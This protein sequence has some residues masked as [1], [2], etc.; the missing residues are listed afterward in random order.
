M[1]KPEVWNNVFTPPWRAIRLLLFALVIMVIA[2]GV[3]ELKRTKGQTSSPC[4]PSYRETTFWNVGFQ[5]EVT[6]VNNGPAINGW[7]VTFMFPT[8]TQTIY[9]LW[10]GTFTQSGQTVTVRNASYNANIPTGG[11]IVFG[12]NANWSGSHPAPTGFTLNGQSCGGGGGA[13]VIQTSVTTLNVNEG[14]SAQLGVRLSSAPASNVTVN[15]AR[16]SGDTDLTVSGGATLTF[17]PTNFGTFQNATISA[18][19]DADSTNGSAIIRAS[20]TGLP[21]VDVTANEVDNDPPPMVGIQTSVSTL[22]VNEGGSAQFGVRLSA[23]PSGGTATVNVMRVSGDTD[24]TV[25]GGATLTF[26]SANFGTFQNVTINA[27]EDAD[28]ANGSAVFRASGTNLGSADVTANEVDNDPPAMIAIQTSVATLNVNEGGSAQYGVRLASAPAATVTV[29]VARLSGDTDLT[30]TGGATLMF[31][32]TNFGTFQNVTISAAQD[33]DMANGSAVIRASGANLISADVTANEVD[34]DVPI[35]IQTNLIRTL[36]VIEN[37][38]ATFGVR[39]AAAPPANVTVNVA[40]LNGDADLR[41]VG[42]GTLTFTP[43]NFSTFQNVT[44][45]A[46]EDADITNGTA[47]FQ[48]SGTG[49]TNAAADVSEFDNDG[50]P[51]AQRTFVAILNGANEVPPV[52]TSASG[53]STVILS[54]DE[55]SALVSLNFTGLGSPQTAAHLHGPAAPGNNAPGTILDLDQPLGQVSNLLWNIQP[56][57]GLSVLQQVVALKSG[58]IY[59][60]VHTANNPSG[61]IRGWLFVI[62]DGIEDPPDPGGGGFADA[63]RFLEQATFGPTVAEVNRVMQIGFDPWLNEQ[64]ALPITGYNNLVTLQQGTFVSYPRKLQFFR[65][66]MTA[67]DQ[68]RQRVAW[69]LS[70]IVVAANIGDQDGNGNPTAMVSQYQ[71]ILLRNAFG[72]YRTLIREMSVS[73]IMGTYLTLVNSQRANT[74]TGA[75]PD[76]NYIRELWQLFTIGTFR[77]NPN[78]TVMLDGQGRPLEAYT[79]AEIQEGARALTGWNYAPAAGQPNQGN[80]NPLNP[81]AAMITNAANHDTGSKTLLTYP[82]QQSTAVPAN[83]T[84]EQ[85]LD[86]VIN[87]VFNHPNVGPFI[88]RQLIQHLVTSNPSPAYVGRITAVFNNNGQ[89]VRGDLR[90]VVRAI[91]LDPE[92]RGNSKVDPAYG[93]LREPALFF[94]H[95]FRGLGCTGGMWGIPQRSRSLGQDIFSPPSVFNYYQPDFRVVVNGQS[96][97]APPAQLLTTSTIIGRFNLLNEFLFAPPIQPGGDPNPTGTPTTSVVLDFAP[98]DQLAPNPTNLVNE[99]NTRLMH[100]SMSAQMRQTVID[101]VT[102]IQNN[103]RLRVQTA[104]YI[105]ASSMQYQVQ[106]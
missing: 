83:Q 29:N 66:A 78:G 84:V 85:D 18:A 59:A 15:V 97:F 87:N 1:L 34:N 21:N 51:V 70:Q 62:D 31:S 36:P 7:T 27:A 104:I 39:L 60:N 43:T 50:A 30:V 44:I 95:L 99:L 86:S 11:S 64:F 92:A 41:V 45:S 88:G 52:T 105:I 72:N 101:A 93:K 65:N 73:P 80:N 38:S 3:G 106:R 48:M 35:A 75:Q 96:I 89:G 82:G 55:T 63:A 33:G 67:P 14:G 54:P 69:A 61:E 100:G 9:E 46:V 37:S 76:E 5:G 17:T 25:G 90:A 77:L 53:T 13:P 4:S 58:Q 56:V 57:G 28:T 98:F 10:H 102:S 74:A 16:L 42:P 94:T 68:L 12:F 2:S 26:T 71:D 20:S 23:A 24:L 79:Q 47:M 49:L 32:P 22:S 8:T 19:E 6:V 103:N 91:L 40:R 81:F